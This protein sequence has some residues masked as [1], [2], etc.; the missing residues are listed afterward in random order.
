MSGVSREV[1]EHN[2]N[3]KPGSKPI[4]QGLRCINQEKRRAMDEELSRLLAAD[5]VKEVQ[6]PDWIANTSLIPKKEWEMVNVCGLHKP[7]QGMPEGS[8]PS[9]LNRPGHG[10]HYRV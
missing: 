10:P 9:P 7:E 8:F 3:I 6:H 1:T 5:F 4:K 2:L